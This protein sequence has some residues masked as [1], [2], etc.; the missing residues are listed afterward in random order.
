MLS[1]YEMSAT[2]QFN[3]CIDIYFKK[4]NGSN[5]DF[6]IDVSVLEIIYPLRNTSYF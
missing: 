1:Y 4:P 2:A 6:V 3:S 5:I